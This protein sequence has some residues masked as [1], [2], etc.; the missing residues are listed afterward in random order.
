MRQ[1]P[2]GRSNWSRF[3][4]QQHAPRDASGYAPQAP[5]SLQPSPQ[6][7]QQPPPNAS[8]VQRDVVAFVEAFRANQSRPSAPPN[9]LTLDM[10]VRAVCSHFRVNAFE[11]LMGTSALQLLALRQLHTV[12]QRVWTFVTCF[13]QSR[14]VNTLF[15]CQQAFLQHEGLRNF[16]EL[17][18]GNSFLHT[19]AVQQLYRSPVALMAV[20]TSDVLAAL[21]QFEDMLGHDAFRASSHIDLNEFLQFLAQQYRQPS[22]QAMGV[23]IDPSGFGV[24]VGML[25]RV[26]NNE[27]KEMKTLEQQFQREVAEKMFR[28]TKEKFSDDNRKRALEELLEQTN[29]RS[30]QLESEEGAQMRRG[31][32]KNNMQSLSLDMLKR[33][34][35]VDVYLDNVLRRKAAADAKN[36]QTYRKPISSQEIAETD[37]KLRNQMTRFLVSSQK[38]RH[39]SRLKVV[40]WVV[41]SI[42]AKTYALLLSDDKIPDADGDGAEDVKK[43]SESDKEECDCCCVGKDTCTCSC[44][45]KCHVESSDEEEEEEDGKEE[46]TKTAKS[47]EE[48]A[49]RISDK[50]PVMPTDP[51]A[52]RLAKVAAAPK[53]TLEEVEAEVESFLEAQSPRDDEPRTAKEVLQVLSSL[54]SHLIIKFSTKPNSASWAGRRSVLELLPDLLDSAEDNMHDDETSAGKWLLELLQSRGGGGGVSNSSSPITE[55][56]LQDEVLPFVRECRDVISSSSSL[57]ALSSERQQQWIARRV[58]VELGCARVED[59]GLPSME[60]MIKLADKEPAREETSVVK[61]AGSLDLPQGDS[62]S[63]DMVSS[64]ETTGESMQQKLLTEQALEKLRKCPYL[65]D[66]S[67]YMDWQE[68]YAPL[69]GSLL[70]FIRVHEMILLDHAPSSNNFMFVSCLNGTILR[71][72]EKSTPSDLELLCARAQQANTHVAARQVAVHLVSMVVTCKGQANFPKQ[73]VQAHLRAYLSSVT[74]DKSTGSYPE[75]FALEVLLETPVEFADFVMSLLLGVLTQTTGSTVSNESGSADRVWKACRSD[76]ERKALLYVSS[77]SLSGLWASEMVKWCSLRDSPPASCTEDDGDD[78]ANENAKHAATSQSTSSTSATNDS[79][80]DESKIASLFD[81]SSPEAALAT[82]SSGLSAQESKELSPVEDIASDDSCRS[83]IDDLRRKQFG[84]GLQIQDEATTSVLRIQ[85][86]R[87]ER[88]LKR[89]SD[90]L[91]SESTHFVLELLQNADDNTYDDAV[92]PLGDFTLT[93]DKE[94]VF[95]NNERGFSP[96]NIQAICDVGASTKEAADSEASIG[97]KGIGFKSVFKVSDNPQVHSNGFHICFH[98]KSAQ[99]GTGMGYILPYWLDDV[100]HWKQR[101][102]TT[103]VLPLN[104]TSVQRVDDISQSLMAFEPSVLLFLRRIRELRLRDSARQLALHFLKKEKQLHANAQIVELYSQVKKSESSVEVVQQNWLVVKEKLEPPQLFTRSH[105]AEIAIAF[106]LTFQGEDSRPPLQE[107]FAYLPLRSYGFRF[108]LQGDFE[109]PSSREA[110]T[111][112]SEWN[113]WLVSKFP[114]L[115]RAAVSSYVSSIQTSD[116][117]ADADKT[118]GAISHLLS[119]LPLENEVQAPFRSIIPEVMRELRQ[120]KWLLS[121]SSAMGGF[122]MP[123]ELID[124]IEL[125]GNEASESTTT[126]LEALSEDVLAATF[127]KRFLHPALSRA[128]TASM[129][130]QL[131]I[132]QLHS[133]HLMRVLSLSADKDSID[134]TV[135]ILALL[136]KLWRKDRHSKL[137]RQELRLIKCFPL[138]RKGRDSSTK[139]ISLAEAHDSLFVSGARADDGSSTRDKSYEFYGDLRI[140]DDTFTKAINKSSRL[141]AFLMNDVGIHV[142][143]DHDLIRHH[144]LPKMTELRSSAEDTNA[145]IEAGADVGVVIEYGRFLSSHLVSCSNCPMQADVKANMVVATSSR[146]VVSADNTNLLVILPS[147]LKEMPQLASW[148]NTQLESSDQNSLAIVSSEYFSGTGRGSPKDSVDKQWQQLL[149]D[150]CELPLL[151]D[152]ASLTSDPRSQ[153]GMEKVLKWIEAEDDIAVKRSVSTSLAQYFDKHWSSAEDKSNIDGDDSSTADDKEDVVSMWRQY[154]WLEGSDGQFYRSTDLWLSAETTTRLLTSAMVTFSAMTWKSDDFAKRVLGLRA[155]PTTDDVLPV[156]SSL[157]VDSTLTSTIE[158]DQMIPLYAFLWEECQRSDACRVEITK[159]FSRKSMLFVPAE[160]D[161]PQRFIGVKNAVWT[162]TAHNGEL[163]ALET[164]YPKTL[165]EFFT[166]VC[167]VQRKPSVAF[168]CEMITEHQGYFT[169]KLS[170]SENTKA[171]KKKMLP[172]L[173]A[174]SKKVKKRSLS[175]AEIKVIKK[176]LKSTPWLPVRSVGGLSNV[177]MLCSSKDSPVHA[178]TEKEKKLQKLLVAVAKEASPESSS[179]KRKDGDGIKLVHLG[180]VA[181]DGDLD[182][183]LSMAKISTLSAHL[184]AKAS[185]WCKVL[186]RFTKSSA[187]DNKKSRKKLLK[188]LQ[189]VVK[190]WSSVLSTSSSSDNTQLQHSVVFPTIDDNHQWA[191]AADMYINDQTDL[192]KSDFQ[193]PGHSDQLQ[194]LGLFPWNYF[195]DSSTSEEDSSEVTRVQKILTEI[196]GMKSLKEHLQYEVSVLSTQRPASEAFHEKLRSAFALAQR[197]LIHSHRSLYDQL[198]HDTIAKLAF[199]LQ[200][201]LVDGHDG[202][203]VV[204]RVGNSFSLRRGVDAS[205]QCFLD[206]SNSTLYMQSVTG[207]EEASALSPVLM[208]ISRKL[209]G[210]QVATSVANLLYLSLLQPSPQMREQWLVETQLL[211]PLPSSEADKLWVEDTATSTSVLENSGRKRDS[212]DMEDGEIDAEEAPMKKPYAPAQQNYLAAQDPQFAPLPPSANFD[213]P[214]NGAHYGMPMQRHPSYPPLPPQPIEGAPFHPPLPPPSPG[215]GMQS[216]SLPHTMTKEERAAIGRWGEEYVFNQLKQQHAEKE[217]SLTVEWVNEKEESGLPYDLTLSSAGKVVEYI[218]VKST[219]TMEKGVFEISM[220][221][222][223]QA[224][225]HGS[226]YSIYRVFNAGNP[227]LCRVIRMKNPVSLVRQRRI[228]LALVMQ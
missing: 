216:L 176:T 67:L 191:P 69:C 36:P 153:A 101:R 200:C 31:G 25:R 157:S 72:N 114:K 50:F 12:N 199:E 22:A 196:C 32:K 93:A 179:K 9:A 193:Q 143:E 174:L 78:A 173:S 119:L 113:E 203:Q 16:H 163:V 15:E 197:F 164:Q 4:Q 28:L 35:D 167:G 213:T 14:R 158:I 98:A 166:D 89:L 170:D 19:E 141:R 111:N 142:M 85:Q 220:N 8:Q 60:E 146:R 71:V 165:C 48:K 82:F 117:E 135:K 198:E 133:S 34:T 103:F 2:G 43:V 118:V 206:I 53:V 188:L 180:A 152:A 224:A 44:T 222:L 51:F 218:E 18:M 187:L 26:A 110:I 94:I 108:I 11:D 139:W 24:Y 136:A 149:V 156:I 175:K 96:A 95:Y 162:S 210:A 42:M 226:T 147:T 30:T 182:A 186:A 46:T 73:L 90:E 109:I 88:A 168:L 227:A 5:Y 27:M 181:D 41:C 61:F 190:I 169:A 100:A 57:S 106:P 225:I 7:Y 208:E 40:T 62:S 59:L 17:K 212:E 219:R 184:E 3:Q 52:R 214:G 80:E 104:D 178:T 29:A 217:S 58:F 74:K 112:G 70:S 137:L 215:S 79:T 128:M 68:R 39:H 177:L 126:L 130:S 195:V 192:S 37:S 150:V 131:R 23:L 155:T 122:L 97:K 148:V 120:V 6:S 123:S 83:F 154:C 81:A 49:S 132:E 205:S 92:V 127:N 121:A 87:L 99:H 45:C 129:K 66:V 91:Y 38:S 1:P 189:F 55:K 202:F 138:Q 223:D 76:A 47:D 207:D 116:S 140:L 124:C 77:R 211:P 144:I 209:F 183:L 56:R 145:S 115:V 20:T 21:K 54:E 151:F 194:V 102:G 159:A 65:V 64:N 105:P 201:M 204:Y 228:Q 75:R 86:Q 125:T 13:V 33:V 134:W 161:K 221:E 10:V 171:W 107:V 63:D 84:V 172:L 160:S 185:V